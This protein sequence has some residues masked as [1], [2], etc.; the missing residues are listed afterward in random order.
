MEENEIEFPVNNEES[1]VGKSNDGMEK[2][3]DAENGGYQRHNVA[4]D[5]SQTRCDITQRCKLKIQ[6]EITK[7]LLLEIVRQSHR[8]IRQNHS[9]TMK[10]ASLQLLLINLL[11]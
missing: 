8:T 3:S 10:K 11:F 6:Q 7:T 9:T 4:Y 5:G 2:N 1:I